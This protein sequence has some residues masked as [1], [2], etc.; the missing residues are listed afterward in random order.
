MASP[1]ARSRSATVPR[2]T[3]RRSTSKTRT[4]TPSSSRARPTRRRSGTMPDGFMTIGYEGAAIEAFVDT[5]GAAGVR[6]LIDVRDAPWSRRPEYAKRALA[7]ALAAGG[8]DYRH[9]KGL[10][11]PKPGRDAARAGDIETFPRHLPGPNGRRGGARRSRHGRGAC[12]QRRRL[13]DVL[14]AR[15]GPLPPLDRRRNGSARRPASPCATS[16][17]NARPRT[18]PS[19]ICCRARP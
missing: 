10:G 11:N 12:R 8:I 4:A 7:E 13:P 1:P 9:L 18:T 14:R 2:A 19:S 6:T 17:S 15:R 16:R 3:G 5:L